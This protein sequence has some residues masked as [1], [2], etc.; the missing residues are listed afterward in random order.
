MDAPILD[1]RTAIIDS[2][3]KSFLEKLGKAL[4]AYDKARLRFYLV[5][6][7]TERVVAAPKIKGQP[8]IKPG[9]IPAY[10]RQKPFPWRISFDQSATEQIMEALQKALSVKLTRVMNE[11]SAFGSYATSF[12]DQFE[13]SFLPPTGCAEIKDPLATLEKVFA[14]MDI[15]A[16]ETKKKVAGD[17]KWDYQQLPTKQSI[18]TKTL[19]VFELNI[20]GD[21]LP[22]VRVLQRITSGVETTTRKSVVGGKLGFYFDG[23]AY[24]PAEKVLSFKIDPHGCYINDQMY[25]FEPG[26]IEDAL[27]YQHIFNQQFPENWEKLKAKLPT[28]DVTEDGIA[29][30]VQKNMSLCKTLSAVVNSEEIMNILSIETVQQWSEETKDHF[31]KSYSVDGGKIVIDGAKGFSDLL[32]TCTKRIVSPVSFKSELRRAPTSSLIPRKKLP[33]LAEQD[34]LNNKKLEAANPNASTAPAK[35]TRKNA[36]ATPVQAAPTST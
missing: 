6:F 31:S 34:L 10:H 19:A 1:L 29:S 33:S 23:T 24:H 18:S 32:D 5:N 21:D 12:V 28:W 22:N 3:R 8:A 20:P 11:Q 2:Q 17:D 16:D 25:F 9:F 27:N 13:V 4:G 14:S 36:K 15:E 7:S 26:E 30:L 35:K